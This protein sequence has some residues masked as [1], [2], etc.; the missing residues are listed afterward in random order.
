[1]AFSSN[2]LQRKLH[3]FLG[4]SKGDFLGWVEG[5]QENVRQEGLHRLPCSGC[6]VINK[7]MT[8]QFRSVPGPMPKLSSHQFLPTKT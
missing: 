1:M 5:D 6:L 3:R 7:Q 4:I 2:A 8:F